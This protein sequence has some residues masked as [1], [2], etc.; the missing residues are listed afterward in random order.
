MRCLTPC[1]TGALAAALAALGCGEETGPDEGAGKDGRETVTGQPGGS[2]G[3]DGTSGSA[4][5][6]DGGVSATCLGKGKGSAATHFVIDVTWPS[7][8]AIEAGQG[9][10]HI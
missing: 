9:Q 2:G 10:I 1:I 3:S 7:S 6:K 8:L 4:P 5:G